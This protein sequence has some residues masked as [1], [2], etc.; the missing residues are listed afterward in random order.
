MEGNDQQHHD[1]LEQGECTP[2]FVASGSWSITQSRWDDH[3]P[4][5]LQ[6]QRLRRSIAGPDAGD[7]PEQGHVVDAR[8]ALWRPPPLSMRTV[9]NFATPAG[10]AQPD[11]ACG[12]E[13]RVH[14]L[15]IGHRHPGRLNA[16]LGRL[17]PLHAP[18]GAVEPGE[19]RTADHCQERQRATTASGA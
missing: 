12:F 13:R 7:D 16:Q 14:A 11:P 3:V 15:Q 6:L 5:K 8:T 2:V 1:H 9:A 19:K 10:N 18:K 4:G 17:D